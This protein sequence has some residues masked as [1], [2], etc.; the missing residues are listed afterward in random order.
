MPS[1]NM[2]FNVLLILMVSSSEALR[3]LVFF[4]LHSKSHSILGQGMV[5]RLLEAGHE[6]VHI[7]SFPR[8]KPEAN[9]TEISL[10]SLG[11]RMKAETEKFEKFKLKNL[12]GKGNFG[13]SLFFIYF[14]HDIHKQIL[15][16]PDLVKFLSDPKE[17]FDAVILEWF[18]ADEIAGIAPLFNCP[19]IWFGSTEAHW[20]VLKLVDEIPN[21]SYTVDLFSTSTPPLSFWERTQELYKMLKKLLIIG[22]LVTPFE[23]TI[24]NNVFK[25]I[26]ADRGVTIPSYDEAVYNGSM[27]LLNSHPSIGTPFRLPQNAKYVGGYHS[28]PKVKSLPK[29]LKKIMDDAK[30]GVIYFSMGSNLKSVDM[31]DHMKNSLLT[32]FGKLK[33]TVI[34]KFEGDLDNVPTNIHLLKWAPQQSILAHPNLKFFIT[35][36]GQLSTTEA[37]HFGV[38]VIGI[39]VLGDQHVNMG[40]VTKK[41]FGIMVSLAENMAEKLQ[42]AIKEMLE[43]AS[44]RTK[45]KELSF[46]FHSRQQ[47]PGDELI[48]WI[49]YVVNTRGA[50][51]L[52][53][54]ALSTPFYKKMYF[55]LLI[56]SMSVLYLLVTYVSPF[57]NKDPPKNL[58]YIDVSEA[59]KCINMGLFDIK[60][61]MD[62]VVNLQDQNLI[63][64]VLESFWECS[65]K[66]ETLQRFLNDP[67][68]KFDVVVVEWLYSE[69]G[70]GFA[71]AF[72][73][74]LIWSS[75]MDPHTFILSLVNEHLNPAYT[76]HHMSKDY[77]FSFLDRVYQLWSVFRVRYYQ[78]ANS[79]HENEIFK[80]LYGPIVAKKGRELPHFDDV[81]Y[82]ASLVL[83]NSDIV[84]GDG[85]ALP[86][87][88]KHIGGYHFKDV[89]EPLPKDLKEIIDNATNGVIYFSMGSNLKSSNIPDNIKR[90]LLNMFSDLKETVIWKLEKTIPDLPKNV[91][92]SPWVP[93][94][95]LLAHP[96]CILFITHGGLLSILETMHAGKPI[97]GIPFFADQYLNVNRAVAKGFAK[98]IDFDENV[99]K[100]LK[101]AIKEILENP[102]YKQRAKEISVQFNDRIVPPGQ[103]LV[104]WIEHVIKT[105]GAPHLRSAALH[106]S[107]Y[108]KLYLDLL[109][110][111]VIA[112]MVL[113]GVCKYL[114]ALQVKVHQKKKVQ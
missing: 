60:V 30:H 14:T 111:I 69:L 56:V 59:T 73:S 12:V 27:L 64:P 71:T 29:E 83:G 17:K 31:S 89:V 19:L 86:Q 105:N 3:L 77:S 13:D 92:I 40:S 103:E 20:Q 114:F 5:S 7:T 6:V 112:L 85:I 28:D 102:S 66:I 47:K 37:I 15:S 78:W 76:V 34:W 79:N 11:I 93:Q 24:Y 8:E 104:F 109:L 2:I 94:Q 45:A 49:E 88:Y 18:F 99:V 87:N 82:N 67:N 70:S 53:S 61:I 33:Q 23:K 58:R 46:I 84:A 41:G 91:Y 95:S 21:P 50:P 80:Q 100:P 1:K 44:Y 25:K 9:L 54:P 68:E 65:F 36:G 38:P 62:K 72:N 63:L 75:S 32:M 107:W 42:I 81:K 90:E 48:F 26:A 10:L 98:R 52:R 16:D 4:P 106:V 113:L 55:D 110:I 51:H 39:P 57:P 101:E 35:H 96:N 74:P 108:K 97:I 43:N 22:V